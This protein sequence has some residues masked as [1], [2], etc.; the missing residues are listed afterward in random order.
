MTTI[1]IGGAP[2]SGT[3]LAQS[4]LC[5]DATTNPMLGEPFYFRKI[6][7]AY[8]Q[9][10]QDF[11]KRGAGF[12][13][14]PARLARF[15]GEPRYLEKAQGTLASFA[16]PII[17]S[18][19][20]FSYMLL[21]ADALRHGE[22]GPSVGDL[23]G[24]LAVRVH[25]DRVGLRPGAVV[26][27]RL[28]LTIRPGWHINSN[29]PNDENL[30]PTVLS[31]DG[32]D[33]GLS[34]GAVEFPQGVEIDLPFAEAAMSVYQGEVSI[35]FRLELAEGAAAGPRLARLQLRYQACDDRK[36]LAPA[37]LPLVLALHPPQPGAAP[38]EK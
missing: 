5:S 37:E 13:G 7:F 1:F 26:Q 10:R 12:F 17:R 16:D 2:R 21:A 19:M 23:R 32:L 30:V 22:T 3:T 8:K 20:S 18:P 25:P 29:R 4:I 6:V 36:C 38:V 34:L 11:A 15:T 31:G 24:I 35:P 27:G 28:T 9:T 14:D 33:D